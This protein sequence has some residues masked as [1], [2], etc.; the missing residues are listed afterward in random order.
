MP[1]EVKEVIRNAVIGQVKAV[2][3]NDKTPNVNVN[4]VSKGETKV[5]PSVLSEIKGKNVAVAFHGG[6]GFA[7]SISGKDLGDTNLARLGNLDLTIDST[8]QNIPASVMASKPG[9]EK[10]QIAVKDTGDFAVPVNIHVG[11]GAENEGK[12][13][14]LYRY[15][16]K[17]GRLE[18]VS[19][20][21]INEEGQ[22]MFALKKGGDYLV[23]VADMAP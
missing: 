11:V 9:T 6:N 7:L 17:Y 10:K 16:A 4:F 12:Y 1:D 19:S 13:A 5:Q 23:T 2:T 18:Y 3:R 8:A 14:L 20:Y 22:S 15:D 21:Q